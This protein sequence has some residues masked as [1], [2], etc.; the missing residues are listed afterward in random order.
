MLDAAA[1]AEM[2]RANPNVMV[3][4]DFIDSPLDLATEDGAADRYSSGALR[5]R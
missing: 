4:R 5:L 2:E 3:S 1:S